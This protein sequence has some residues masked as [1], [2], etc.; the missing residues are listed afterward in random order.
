[1]QVVNSPSPHIHTQYFDCIF[2]VLQRLSVQAF[3]AFD[4]DQDGRLSLAEFTSG[5]K[6]L[7]R[8]CR[9]NRRKPSDSQLFLGVVR[10]FQVNEAPNSSKLTKLFE[11]IDCDEDGFVAA[12]FFSIS[13]QCVY[14]CF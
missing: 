8:I 10:L 11:F 6:R 12:G 9:R 1:M 4:V 14:R 13:H 7:Q 2:Y 3:Y 5:S